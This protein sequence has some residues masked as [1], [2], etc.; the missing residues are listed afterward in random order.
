MFMR[1][2]AF[3][4]IMLFSATALGRPVCFTDVASYN[5][6][7]SQLPASMRNGAI[8]IG[9]KTDSLKA[10]ASIAPNSAGQFNF[11]M[12][13][14]HWLAGKVE[15]AGRIREICVSGQQVKITLS[16]GTTKTLELKG[17]GFAYQGNL[18]SVISRG[19]SRSLT[20][21]IHAGNGGSAGGS[22]STGKK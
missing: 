18:L 6:V 2:T 19:E 9:T 1:N 12:I 11:S 7:K 5:Q 3:A 15:D 14:R 13:Y 17:R 10:T 16:T 22:A 21:E 20:S 4:L 8:F